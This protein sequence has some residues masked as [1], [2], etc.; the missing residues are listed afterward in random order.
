MKKMSAKVWRLLTSSS[1]F[2]IQD[3]YIK[4][5]IISQHV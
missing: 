5:K 2:Q 3:Y 4:E 1:V